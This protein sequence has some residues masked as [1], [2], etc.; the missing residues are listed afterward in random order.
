MQRIGENIDTILEKYPLLTYNIEERTFV[1]HIHVDEDDNYNLKI[2]IKNFPK[3]FPKVY[4]LDDRIPKKSDR[5]IFKDFS[6]CF[7]TKVN[8]E[9]F[10]KTKV[11]DLQSFFEMIL[12]PYLANNSFYEINNQYKFGEY[13]HCHKIS[14]YQTYKDILKLEN[15]DLISNIL[16]LI[17]KGKK[18]RPNDIC[19]CGSK[20]KIKKCKNHEFAYKNL[21]K[22]NR[23]RL[24]DDSGKISELREDFI[25]IKNKSD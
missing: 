21:R 9:I 6:L 5:H 19:F 16:I 13:S 11:K 2:E 24:L 25:K 18:F 17:G 1:G 3:A 12:I 8:E 22:I 15:F 10:L 23:E 7:T 4:E 20:L 14:I